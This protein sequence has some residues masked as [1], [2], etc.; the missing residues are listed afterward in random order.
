MKDGGPAFPVSGFCVDANG[1]LCG[2]TVKSS[3]MSRRDY[4][5]A[6]A[7]QAGISTAN[8]K[9]EETLIAVVFPAIAR[10][11]YAMADAMIAASEKKG[12]E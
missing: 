5:A 7:M 3:G 1:A 6:K 2:E 4:L 9:D 10:L 8:A 11:S 12:G